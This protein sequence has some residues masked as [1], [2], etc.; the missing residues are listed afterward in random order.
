MQDFNAYP[1]F[2][3]EQTDDL[4]EELYPDI[5]SD[6]FPA[7]NPGPATYSEVHAVRGVRRNVPRTEKRPVQAERFTTGR[8]TAVRRAP[9]PAPVSLVDALQATINRNRPKKER[10]VIAGEKQRQRNTDRVSSVRPR[11]ARL[12]SPGLQLVILFAVIMLLLLFTLLFPMRLSMGR[13]ALPVQ[14]A[15]RN[16]IAQARGLP[17]SLG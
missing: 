9:A 4:A 16:P 2:Q 11:P 12:L 5:F 15:V 7:V 14:I 1:P 10:V 8:V 3:S 17:Q 6:V 13:E